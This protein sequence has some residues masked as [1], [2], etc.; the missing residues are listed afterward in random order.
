MPFS[1]T[2][3]R[4]WLDQALN[5]APRR[6]AF[7]I[8]F[9]S[10]TLVALLMMTLALAV[11]YPG[12]YRRHSGG[13]DL[14]LLVGAI[15]VVLGPTLTAVVFDRRKAWRELARD[16]AVIAAIQ[17]GALGYGIHTLFEARPVALVFET[18]R[19]R[20]IAANEVRLQELAD[21]QS[22]YHAL[23]LTGPLLLGTRQPRPGDEQLHALEIALGGYDLGQRP[24]FW[25]AYDQSRMEAFNK[26]QPVHALLEMPGNDRTV[27]ERRLEALGA[28]P[29]TGRYLSLDARED[30]WLIILAPG[31]KVAGFLRAQL[32]A[33]APRRPPDQRSPAS[34]S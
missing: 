32:P 30:G 31:G 14:L 5:R 18:D 34:L 2:S 7:L 17:L 15:D 11:W 23:P 8:H 3:L 33:E 16:L 1:L 6:V 24:I 10:S 28:T 9:C 4:N 26:A 12:D 25:Q 21:P 27:L 22:R 29:S 19:F 13:L 20:V